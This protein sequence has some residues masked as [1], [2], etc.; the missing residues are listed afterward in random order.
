MCTN[1]A[2]T[3]DAS[4]TGFITH[5]APLWLRHTSHP[6]KPT[7]ALIATHLFFHGVILRSRWSRRWRW[8]FFTIFVH[9]A[10]VTKKVLKKLGKIRSK[11]AQKTLTTKLISGEHFFTLL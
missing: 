7:S 3:T 4:K 10:N 2:T 6:P 5:S 1:L 11:E 9:L 8:L